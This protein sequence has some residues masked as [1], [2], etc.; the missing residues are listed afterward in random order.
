METPLSSC[1]ELLVSHSK[2]RFCLR[3]HDSNPIMTTALGVN[4]GLSMHA[5]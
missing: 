2:V 5:D 3:L 1:I 4:G